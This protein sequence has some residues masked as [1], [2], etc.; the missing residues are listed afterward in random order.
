MRHCFLGRWTCQLVSE[1]YRLVWRCRLFDQ[2]TYIP[3]CVHWH[4]D[5]CLLQ[6]VPDYVVVFCLGRVHLP[7]IPGRVIPKTQKMV[8]DTSLLN[9]QHYKVRTKDKVEQSREWSSSLNHTSN[10]AIEKGAYESPLTKVT[11]FTYIY[12]QRFSYSYYWFFASLS[13]MF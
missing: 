2:S 10:I 4:G 5:Q 11:S 13:F 12:V 1:S 7:A 8:L 6:L 3:F 9:T